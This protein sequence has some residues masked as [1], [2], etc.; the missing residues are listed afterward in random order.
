M[1]QYLHKCDYETSHRTSGLQLAAGQRCAPQGLARLP[2][3]LGVDA[4][5]AMPLAV[6][7]FVDACTERSPVQ[8][9]PARDTAHHNEGTTAIMLWPQL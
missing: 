5:D 7:N 1:R 6:A 9:G 8:E 2:A 3:V 4:V